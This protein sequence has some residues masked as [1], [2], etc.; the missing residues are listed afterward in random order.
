MAQNVIAIISDCDDTLCPDTTY[1]LVCDLGLEPTGFWNE[2]SSLVEDG[3]NPPLAYLN[4][5][6]HLAQSGEIVPIT[7]DKLEGVAGAVQFY[8]GALDFVGRLREQL[9]GNIEFRNADVSIDWYIVSSGIEGILRATHLGN[10]ANDIFGCAFEY[11]TAGRAIAVKRAVT[12]TEKT[13]F[14][15]A[16]S[17]G[18]SG[19]ELRRKPYLVN[20]VVE[21]DERRVPFKHMIYMGDGPS[22]IPCF[23][24]LKRGGG[25]AIGVMAPEDRELRKPYELAQGNRLTV[26]PYTADYRE[27]SDLFKMLW[28]IV[29]GIANSILEDR[30]QRIRPAPGF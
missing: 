11:D 2:V 6:L 25:H 16:I 3:W 4:R 29:E 22:D 20:D 1:R 17:K 30:A 9:Q 8:P 18:I 23:S 15:F 10:L 24:M 7:R 27:G 21:P 26:G 14:I 28:P 12:F 19:D 13:K 5:L